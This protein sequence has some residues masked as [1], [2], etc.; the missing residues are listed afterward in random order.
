MARNANPEYWQQVLSDQSASG[1]TQAEWCNQK[2]V[3]IHNFRYWKGRLTAAPDTENE[4]NDTTWAL[5][6]SPKTKDVY[7]QDEFMIRIR[8]GKA[9]VDVAA[10]V[11]LK[12]LARVISVLMQHVQ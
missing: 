9:T 5:I 7:D 11:D 1:L 12:A 2:N 4:S 8:I 3:N 6:T 10:D